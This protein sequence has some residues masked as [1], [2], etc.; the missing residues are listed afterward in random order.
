MYVVVSYKPGEEF[1]NFYKKFDCKEDAEEFLYTEE[2]DFRTRELFNME[3]PKDRQEFID[4]WCVDYQDGDD[5]AD[6]DL[7]DEDLEEMYDED[8]GLYVTIGTR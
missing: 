2:F 5:P 4:D 8:L 6:Y 3:D 1:Y 7:N